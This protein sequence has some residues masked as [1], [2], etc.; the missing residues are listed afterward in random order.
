MPATLFAACLARL[1][2]SQP[3]AARLLGWSVQSVKD[4]CVGRSR[5]PDGVWAE[6]RAIEAPIV[7]RSDTLASVLEQG[8]EAAGSAPEWIDTVVDDHAGLM[9]LADFLLTND[10]LPGDIQVGIVR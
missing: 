4:R 3:E 8:T 10:V 9:G 5:V 6:L 7:E 2:L 1:G